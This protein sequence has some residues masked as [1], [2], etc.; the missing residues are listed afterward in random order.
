MD[1]IIKSKIIYLNWSLLH[2]HSSSSKVVVVVE[3]GSEVVVEEG[4]EVVVEEGS[5][6]V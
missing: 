3:E 1:R 2:T 5:K 4:S 6:E